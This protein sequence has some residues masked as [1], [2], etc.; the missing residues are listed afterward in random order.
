MSQE[1][2][3]IV[4]RVYDAVSRRDTAT[5][6]AA[7]DPEIEWD[8]T[9]LPEAHLMGH[10]FLRGHE[11]LRTLFRDWYE[12]WESAEDK[13]E[14]LIDAGEHVVSVVTRRG[15]GRASGTETATRRAGVW[16]IRDGKI[17]RAVW[18]TSREDALEAVGLRE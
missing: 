3:Q 6:L 17:V 16:T 4:R 13:C 12:A 7:Y 18:F 8:S 1:N 2:V 14:E 15:R 11:E 9:R 5:V 10:A